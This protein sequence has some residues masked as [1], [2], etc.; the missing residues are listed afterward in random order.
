MRRT[1]SSSFTPRVALET[2]LS[3]DGFPLPPFQD[4][5]RYHHGYRRYGGPGVQIDY[6]YWDGEERECNGLVVDKL[7]IAM[8]AMEIVSAFSRVPV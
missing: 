7:E 2:R 5:N 6:P 1:R 4:E 8:M 3:H